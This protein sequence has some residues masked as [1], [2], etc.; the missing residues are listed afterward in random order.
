MAVNAVSLE[1]PEG[2]LLHWEDWTEAWTRQKAQAQGLV[3]EPLDWQLFAFAREFYQVH[4]VMP[5]T[6]RLIKFVRETQPN[7]DSLALQ[8]RYG[9]KPLRVIAQCAGLPKPIQCI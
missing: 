4:Q 9:D 5:L 8:Q 2:Y 1:T 3:L 7:F 6:R